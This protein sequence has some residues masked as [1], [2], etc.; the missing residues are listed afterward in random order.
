MVHALHQYI[1]ALHQS[2]AFPLATLGYHRVLPSVRHH[3]QLLLAH[4][5]YLVDQLSRVDIAA[6]G[7]LDLIERV[8]IQLRVEQIYHTNAIEGNSMALSLVR[9][10]IVEGPPSGNIE[11]H[12]YELAELYGSLE[13]YDFTSQVALTS[14]Q[15]YRAIQ[16]PPEDRSLELARNTYQ[17]LM[18]IPPITWLHSVDTIPAQAHDLVSTGCAWELERFEYPRS[19]DSYLLLILEMHQKVLRRA[20]PDI[21]G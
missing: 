12:P 20:Q 1:W 17:E 2:P 9:E 11:Y 15:S 7:A 19:A 4:Y 6:P 3:E 5:D 14:Y 16:A 10:I 18:T 21:A 13:A 8:N